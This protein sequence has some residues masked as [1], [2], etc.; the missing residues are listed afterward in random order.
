MEQATGEAVWLRA[1][2][3]NGVRADTQPP[4]EVMADS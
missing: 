3:Q 4:P 2:G 1:R